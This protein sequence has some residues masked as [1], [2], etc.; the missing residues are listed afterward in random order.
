M[1]YQITT[2]DDLSLGQRAEYAKTITDAD[3]S[4]F[5]AITGD[6]NP[7]HINEEFARTTFFGQRI[8]HGMLSASLFSTMVWLHLPGIGAIYRSQNIEFKRPVHIGDT[9]T[10]VFVITEIDP[11][12]NLIR[13]D[14]FIENQRGERVIDGEACASL[15]LEK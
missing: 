6:V 10:A 13:F 8:A 1:N 11:D 12:K 5:V 3:I 7:L 14:S 4:H 2:F 15:I 9:I